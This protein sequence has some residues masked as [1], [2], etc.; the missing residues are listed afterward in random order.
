MLYK[1]KFLRGDRVKIAA[2]KD[3]YLQVGGKEA[4]VIGSYRDQYGGRKNIDQFS[5]LVL[6]KYPFSMSWFDVE[7][8]TLVDRKRLR[9]EKLLQKHNEDDEEEGDE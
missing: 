4:I 2:R 8:L 1:Q 6:S 5:L 3:D 7:D 9:G